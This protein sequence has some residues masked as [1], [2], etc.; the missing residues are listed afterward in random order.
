MKFLGT[1]LLVLGVLVPYYILSNGTFYLPD[2]TLENLGFAPG[3]S[4]SNY[5]THLFTHVGLTHLVSNLVPLVAF[6]LLLESSVA[7]YHVI[8]LFLFSGILSS[9]FFSFLNPSVLLIGASTGVSGLMAASTLLK[10]KKALVFLI[11]MLIL[12][13]S[14]A[15]TVAYYNSFQLSRMQEEKTQLGQK[16]QALLAQNKTEEAKAQNESLSQVQ[17]KITQTTQGIEREQQTPTDLLVHLFG[18]GFGA[19]YL[20]LFARKSLDKGLLEFESLGALFH[21][22]IS[23]VRS[24][25]RRKKKNRV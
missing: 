18:A 17:V 24:F 2:N 13:A 25:F 23:G 20:I 8:G 14:F 5:V 10:P 11:V 6:G 19:L 12:I 3:V 7:S 9:I 16:V 1:L 4:L 15:P 22:K 21:S